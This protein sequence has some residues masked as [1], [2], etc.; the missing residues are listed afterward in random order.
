MS[1]A[2]KKLEALANTLFP[3][4]NDS[5]LWRWEK[6]TFAEL[7][8]KYFPE[9]CKFEENATIVHFLDE[10][11][12]PAIMKVAI[13]HKVDVIWR[14]MFVSAGTAKNGHGIIRYGKFVSTSENILPGYNIYAEAHVRT[15]GK[16]K[17]IEDEPGVCLETI[18]VVPTTEII[19]KYPHTSFVMSQDTMYEVASLLS[20]G[21][22]QSFLK[23]CVPELPESMQ[24]LVSKFIEQLDQACM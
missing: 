8:S 2:T 9:I 3:E 17:C 7:A 12:T 22:L 24:E 4:P 10:D 18:D 1:F 13:D 20:E 14:P 15:A 11:D 5:A 23:A 6:M 16:F 21:M 19:V